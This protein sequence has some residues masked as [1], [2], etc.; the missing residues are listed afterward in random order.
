MKVRTW[1]ALFFL[2][3]FTA[4]S[5]LAFFPTTDPTAISQRIIMMANQITMIGN[6]MAQLTSM[7][8]QLGKLTEQ[9]EH[10][11]E[12]TLG[13]IGAITQPFTDLASVPSKLIGTGMA[14]KSDFSG[15]AGELAT[16]VE[17]FSDGT[18]I[19]QAMRT[20]LQTADT[21][22]EADVL[23][24]YANFPVE[25]ATRAAANYRNNRERGEQSTVLNYA[26]SDAAAETSAAIKSALDSYDGLRNNA[27]KSDTALQQSQ[28]AGMVT[29]GQLTA[30]MAQLQALQAAQD[31][32]CGT[33]SRSEAAGARG[34]LDRSHCTRSADIPGAAGRDYL[35]QRRRRKS[36]NAGAS[37]VYPLIWWRSRKAR[38][39]CF[40]FNST[41]VFQ[42]TSP[43]RSWTTSAASCKG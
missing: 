1:L 37:P 42:P 7:S 39:C 16:A 25:L 22:S 28:V 15:A 10:I 29:Q 14:W 24:T 38:L 12:S 40:K 20:R 27:N 2:P 36:P 34:C 32:G 17:Q 41:P 5:A 30:A 21:T 6:Q 13:Q 9:F 35:T 43:R 26:V 8:N 23:A 18:S 31:G 19:T 3:L 33:G 11:K 4:V